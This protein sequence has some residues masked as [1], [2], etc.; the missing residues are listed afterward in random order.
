MR[1]SFNAGWAVRP[2]QN[3]FSELT[4]AKSAPEPVTL[5]HD[6]MIDTQRDPSASHDIAY[7]PGGV[8]EYSK[9][10]EAPTSGAIAGSPFSSRAC[11]ATPWSM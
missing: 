9:R 6:A 10:F 1:S 5:P 3:P 8:W 7:F 11:T 4:G 2:K